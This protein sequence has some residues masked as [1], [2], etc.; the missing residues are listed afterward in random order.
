M[1]LPIFCFIRHRLKIV[2]R[3]Q[4]PAQNL[5]YRDLSIRRKC[6]QCPAG[7]LITF[8]GKFMMKY[9]FKKKIDKNEIN[10]NRSVF[11]V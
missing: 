6:S 3:T 5:T 7:I 4:N 1:Y 2:T 11:N 9:L 10:N 8:N